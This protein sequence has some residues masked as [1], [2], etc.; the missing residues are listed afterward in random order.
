M[1]RPVK[2]CPRYITSRLLNKKG[3]QIVNCSICAFSKNKGKT[4]RL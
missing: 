1:K 3:K 2:E 4:C